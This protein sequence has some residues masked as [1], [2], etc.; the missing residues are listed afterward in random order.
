M[1]IAT[2]MQTALAAALLLLALP[3]A[4]AASAAA[5]AADDVQATAPPEP[6]ATTADSV[7]ATPSDSAAP[8]G[9]DET[10]SADEIIQKASGFFGATTEAVAKVVERVFSVFGR[11]NAY[12]AGGEGSGAFF[13]GLR[14]G[15][16]NLYMKND[17]DHPTKI[18]WSGP[19]VGFDFGGNV[20]KSF[21]LVYNLRN[22]EEM[23]ERF[24]GVEG[25]AYFVGGIG[26]NYQQSGHVVLAPIRTGVGMRTGINGGYLS[27]A[28]ER[29]WLPF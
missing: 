16:G 6:Q 14:Y 23:Y 24:P 20:S 1:K 21:T 26:V 15:E 5:P 19:S 12:I 18:Y 10:Y 2:L 29:N 28:K 27:Y 25:S 8:L 9:E 11:P 17:A 4:P 7:P 13:V 3:M 22:P